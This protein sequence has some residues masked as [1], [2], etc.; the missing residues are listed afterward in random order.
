MKIYVNFVCRRPRVSTRVSNVSTVQSAVMII[1]C[2]LHKVLSR[3]HKR[4]V[5]LTVNLVSAGALSSWPR[6]EERLMAAAIFR[7]Q[8]EHRALNNQLY[9]E[10]SS[11]S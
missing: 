6:S 7:L 4:K 8:F 2:D 9:D 5:S 11:C 10:I 3:F 1:Y